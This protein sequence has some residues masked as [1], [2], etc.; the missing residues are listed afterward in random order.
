MEKF[1]NQFEESLEHEQHL[2]LIDQISISYATSIIERNQSKYRSLPIE[3]YK[4]TILSHDEQLVE[5]WTVEKNLDTI[6]QEGT[7]HRQQVD[8]LTNTEC[9]NFIVDTSTNAFCINERSN[10]SILRENSDVI[11]HCSP[12]SDY[13][14]DA[15]EKDNDTVT[16]TV[17]IPLTILPSSSFTYPTLLS[18]SSPLLTSCTAPIAPIVYFLDVLALEEKEKNNT[19]KDFLLTIG[20]GQNKM[21]EITNTV[22]TTD[23]P[24]RP[25][26]INRSIDNNNIEVLSTSIIHEDETT[27][28]SIQQQIHFAIENQIENDDTALLIYPLYLQCGHD[29]GANTQALL[30]TAFETSHVH[31][32]MINEIYVY[33]MSLHTE[34][35]YFYPPDALPHMLVSKSQ[36]DELIST[37]DYQINKPEIL[38]FA[39]TN[40]LL[41]NEEQTRPISIKLEQLTYT[42][43][44]HIQ[45]LFP[46]P[47]TCYAEINQPEIITNNNNNNINH[48]LSNFILTKPIK[49]EVKHIR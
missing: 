5:Q 11:S 46:F 23:Q 40:S 47:E 42:E 17:I 12:A 48:F 7:L 26:W 6:Q 44:Y 49:T 20:F 32:P 2:P 8:F 38:S 10:N 45:S 39:Q 28:S 25:T 1:L 27:L 13:E 41:N 16:S 3:W 30:S 37:D 29:L 21:N 24:L 9:D 33:Q 31:L 43:H 35:P 34:F 4:P 18:Q 22:S 19:T 14:T 36:E 15:V